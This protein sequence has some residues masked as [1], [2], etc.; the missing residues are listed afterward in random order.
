MYVDVSSFPSAR[1]ENGYVRNGDQMTPTQLF[2]DDAVSDQLGIGKMAKID[3]N[4][5]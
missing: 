1:G 3:V 4:Q 5:V 2:D